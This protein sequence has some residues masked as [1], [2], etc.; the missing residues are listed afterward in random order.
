MKI[1]VLL[2]CHNRVKT[3]L[4]CLSSLNLAAG[5]HSCDV[6]LVDD[7]STDGTCE[8][9]RATFPSVK[10]ILGSGSLYWAKGMHR[11][12]QEA[13]ANDDYDFYLWLNDDVVLKGNA[14]AELVADYTKTL[15]V[16][17]GACSEEDDD[18]QVSYGATD[19]S[20]KLIVPTGEPQGADGWFTG[21]CVLIPRSIFKSVGLISNAYSH[22]RADYDYA[23]RLKQ[24]GLRFYCSSCYVGVCHNDFKE[25]VSGMGRWSRIKALAQPGYWNLHDLW[26]IKSRYH[27]WVAALIACTHLIWIA[28]KG[29]L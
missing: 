24:Q 29:D 8:Q 12:W 9:V 3:T 13:C 1:A 14:I 26:L 20:D 27:G 19:A 17:I 2:T 28:L 15:S 5:D 6:Y 22:A 25:K 10:I 7:G 18:S 4:R 21:N 16:I 23:E 11:A